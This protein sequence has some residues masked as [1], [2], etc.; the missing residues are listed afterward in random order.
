MDITKFHITFFFVLLWD[1]LSNLPHF[2]LW[3]ENIP[4]IISF[5]HK[6]YDSYIYG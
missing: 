4:I 6:Y 2:P 3:E 5:N 1:Y